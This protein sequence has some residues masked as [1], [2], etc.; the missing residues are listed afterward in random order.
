MKCNIFT[1]A[2][3]G[4]WDACAQPFFEAIGPVGFLSLVVLILL[5]TV[6]RSK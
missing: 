1:R 6:W 4:F 5:V 3:H 2:E